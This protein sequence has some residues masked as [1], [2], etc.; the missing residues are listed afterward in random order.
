MQKLQSC[1]RGVPKRAADPIEQLAHRFGYHFVMHHSLEI[2]V[3][4]HVSTI[5]HGERVG[6]GVEAGFLDAR[7]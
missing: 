7:E 3:L 6:V 4:K 1:V 2:T 5:A